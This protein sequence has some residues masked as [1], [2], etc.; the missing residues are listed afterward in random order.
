[1]RQIDRQQRQRQRQT[2]RQVER[3]TEEESLSQGRIKIE[4]R[5]DHEGFRN[6]IKERAKK[7]ERSQVR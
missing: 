4:T 5:G 2:D 1:M 3:K 7:K 6:K